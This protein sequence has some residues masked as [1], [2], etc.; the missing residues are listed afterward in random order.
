MCSRYDGASGVPPAAFLTKTKSISYGLTPQFDGEHGTDY[1]VSPYVDGTQDIDLEYF[2][3]CQ[4]TFGFHNGSA[5]DSG[6]SARCQFD[7][8]LRD[9]G[10]EKRDFG[11]VFWYS[12]D[13]DAPPGVLD[14]PMAFH[15]FSADRAILPT[16][17]PS[18]TVA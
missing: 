4:K 2:K 18:P 9:A 6:R 11:G 16:L 8:W 17:V 12:L 5:L 3:K 15:D 1:A 7:L 13:G 14:V 10:L